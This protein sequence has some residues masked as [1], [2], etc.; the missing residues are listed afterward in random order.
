KVRTLA[1]ETARVLRARAANPKWIEGQMRHGHRGAAEIAGTI[2]N[3]YALAV[4]SDAVSSQHFELLFEATLGSPPVRNFL[5]G[6]NPKAAKAIAE[7][8]E[9]A[10]ARGFWQTRRNSSHALLAKLREAPA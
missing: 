7:R 6:S 4:L 3:L 2:D 1:E 10:L 9:D 8:F 5:V